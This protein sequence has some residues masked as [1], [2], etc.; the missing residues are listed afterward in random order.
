MKIKKPEKLNY[1]NKPIKLKH[2]GRNIELMIKKISEIKS[3]E[4]KENMIINILYL[5]KNFNS[6]WKNNIND[7]LKI[8]ENIKKISNSKLNINIKNIKIK[9]NQYTNTKSLKYI[10]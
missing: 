3:K 2:Y 5:I 1:K 6:I 9:I 7:E 8:I 4:K 10:S